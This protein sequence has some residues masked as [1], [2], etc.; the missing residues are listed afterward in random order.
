M[1][2]RYYIESFDAMIPNYMPELSDR[3]VRI[4]PGPTIFRVLKQKKFLDPSH[5]YIY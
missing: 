1:M 2:I 5:I 4:N 3:M